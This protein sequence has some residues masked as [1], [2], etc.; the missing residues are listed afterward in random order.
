MKL[1]K[2]MGE[3][4]SIYNPKV[5][6]EWD[7]VGLLLGNENSEINKIMV[8]LD[9]TEKAIN[10]AISRKVDLIISHHPFIFSGIKRITDETELGRKILKLAENRIAVYSIHTNADFAINGLNDFVMD[11]LKLDGEMYIFNEFEF[12]DYNYIKN[13]NEKIKCGSVRIKVLNN[14]MELVDL[15]EQIKTNLGLDYVR[16]A[17][18]NRNIRKIGLV[19]GGGSSFLKDIKK[20][21]DVFLTGDL[22]HHEAL[23]TIEEG[24]ILVDIGHYESEYLFV[25]L[26]ELQLS[27]FFEGEIIKYFGEVVFKLG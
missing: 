14:E 19:T 7:N 23:D 4:F 22:R 8:C 1:R 26:M 6:E 16:Y 20:D 13:K 17:G 18:E 5:A 15:I 9:I 12:D 10:E 2:I 11:K 24:G 3:L 21:I 25:D 27:K